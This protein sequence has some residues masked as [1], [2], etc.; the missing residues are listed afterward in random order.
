MYRDFIISSDSFAD[1]S[2]KALFTDI[3]GITFVNCL[4]FHINVY[5]NNHFIGTV[6][7][8]SQVYFPNGFNLEDILTFSTKKEEIGCYHIT[9]IFL[10]RI[11]IGFASPIHF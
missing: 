1:V 11:L 6:P 3:S 4:P 5:N 2:T 9:D 7:E 10:R 8:N